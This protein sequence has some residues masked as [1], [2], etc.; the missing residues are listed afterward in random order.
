MTNWIES[1]EKMPEKGEKVLAWYAG[2]GYEIDCIE[3]SGS[4]S[5]SPGKEGGGPTHWMPLPAPLGSSRDESLPTGIQ[6]EVVEDRLM[7][8]IDEEKE[9]V[10]VLMQHYLRGD[11]ATVNGERRFIID[12]KNE[13][14]DGKMVSIFFLGE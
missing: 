4:W 5:G 13:M 7:L 9:T 12:M 6:G 2:K 1:S 8:D 3:E 11:A 10:A 14:I